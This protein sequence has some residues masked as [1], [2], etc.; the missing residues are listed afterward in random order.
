MLFSALLSTFT[1]ELSRLGLRMFKT[2]VNSVLSERA[3]STHNLIY[4]KRRNRLQ[5]ERVDKLVFIHRNTRV[6]EKS[7]VGWG[8]I[9]EVELFEMENELVTSLSLAS[10]LISD[11]VEQ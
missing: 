4:D 9:L 1:P 8:S 5:V 2:P 7:A 11:G 6:L 3:F 10:G